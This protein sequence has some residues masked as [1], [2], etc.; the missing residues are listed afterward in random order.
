M[1]RLASTIDELIHF[2]G[3]PVPKS[4][5]HEHDDNAPPC[6]YDLDENGVLTRRCSRTDKQLSFNTN[7][8]DDAM[9]FDA[10]RRTSRLYRTDKLAKFTEPVPGLPGAG[11]HLNVYKNLGAGKTQ[12]TRLYGRQ[13]VPPPP[14]TNINAYLYYFN[15]LT[16]SQHIIQPVLTWRG[17]KKNIF[18]VII[19]LV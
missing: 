19:L 4:M 14:T 2:P 10:T 5:V 3:G 15:G 6:Y 16:N 18:F 7:P 12:F 13:W 1:A 8:T 11:W 9:E 17:D